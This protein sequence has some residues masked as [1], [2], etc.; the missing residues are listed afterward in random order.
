MKNWIEPELWSLKATE[1]E[2]DNVTAYCFEERALLTTDG[3]NQHWCHALNAGAGGWHN[4]GCGH[5]RSNHHQTPD[6]PDH[7]WDGEAHTS[8]CCCGGSIGY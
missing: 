3:K 7:N 5:P 1:T 2:S 4:N 6:N 8:K